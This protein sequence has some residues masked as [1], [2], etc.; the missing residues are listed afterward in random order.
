MKTIPRHRKNPAPFSTKQNIVPEMRFHF[1]TLSSAAFPPRSSPISEQQQE[2]RPPQW[3]T[4][5]NVIRAQK[6]KMTVFIL[7]W[8]KC[9][10]GW[11]FFRRCPILHGRTRRLWQ[12]GRR[13][14]NTQLFKLLFPS[15]YSRCLFAINLFLMAAPVWGT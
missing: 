3:H 10:S 8:K 5:N 9:P 7:P 1:M 12:K 15:C 14:G 4:L 2:K 6:K 11:C 13:A